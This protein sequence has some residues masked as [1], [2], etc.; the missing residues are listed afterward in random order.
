MECVL[1]RR[2]DNGKLAL[3][4]GF[5]DPTESAE[6]AAKRKFSEKALGGKPVSYI[7]IIIGTTYLLMPF[8]RSLIRM[9]TRRLGRFSIEIL[10]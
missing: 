3:P 6:M 1:I 4:G 10:K 9:Y 8:T 7:I 2:K 5:L